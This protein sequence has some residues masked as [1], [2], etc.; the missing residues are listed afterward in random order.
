MELFKKAFKDA[1]ESPEQAAYMR[2][3]EEPLRQDRPYPSL[4]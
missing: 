1:M 4:S 3:P 2:A